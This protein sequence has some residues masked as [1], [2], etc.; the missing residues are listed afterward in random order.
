VICRVNGS[1][2][3][4]LTACQLAL[5]ILKEAITKKA[6]TAKTSAFTRLNAVVFFCHS[7]SK[8]GST[9]HGRI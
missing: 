8:V 5:F 4:G 3:E 1:Q 9:S 2:R 7:T 6:I